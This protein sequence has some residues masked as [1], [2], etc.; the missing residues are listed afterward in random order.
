MC[1]ADAK[2]GDRAAENERTKHAGAAHAARLLL[3]RMKDS[4]L[5]PDQCRAMR[6]SIS[7]TRGELSWAADVPLWFLR[8]RMEKRP[9]PSSRARNSQRDALEAAGVGFLF[10][11]EDGRSK[12][13]SL[14]HS[15]PENEE[16]STPPD[17]L[18]R[19]L[20]EPA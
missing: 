8:S 10:E 18:L 5:S 7:W 12:P 2:A 19:Q 15:L 1:E 17:E 3:R 13:A 14:T 6:A 9:P 16:G 4:S 11:I 20:L